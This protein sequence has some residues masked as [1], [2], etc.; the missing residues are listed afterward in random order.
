MNSNPYFSVLFLP[1][2]GFGYALWSF[3]MRYLAMDLLLFTVLSTQWTLN[4]ESSLEL[5]LWWFLPILFSVLSFWELQFFRYWTSWAVSLLFD[6]SSLSLFVQDLERIFQLY[7]PV[8][9]LCFSSPLLINF[10]KPFLSYGCSFFLKNSTLFLFNEYTTFIFM[11][12]S[13]LI[14]LSFFS[15]F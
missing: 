13:I 12:T 1:L 2:R 5:F 8:L 15:F 14:Y 11:E 9:L 6:V 3:T 4:Q 7:F 10:Q